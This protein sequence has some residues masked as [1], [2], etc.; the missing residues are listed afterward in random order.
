MLMKAESEMFKR[1]SAMA[2][3]SNVGKESGISRVG[4]AVWVFLLVL[5]YQIIIRDF[6]LMF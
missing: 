6:F 1:H 3:R 2:K 5:K 4:S